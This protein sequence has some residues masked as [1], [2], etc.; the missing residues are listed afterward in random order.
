MLL[1][2]FSP[3]PIMS[4]DTFLR[5]LRIATLAVHMHHLKQMLRVCTGM[6]TLGCLFPQEPPLHGPLHSQ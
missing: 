5:H 4:N 2:S 3:A 1:H 6:L